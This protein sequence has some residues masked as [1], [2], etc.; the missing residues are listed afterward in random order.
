MSLI[1]KYYV[2][3]LNV[4]VKIH[5]VDYPDPRLIGLF[6]LVLASW[7]NRGLTVQSKKIADFSVCRNS[8]N[9]SAR[10]QSN[11]WISFTFLNK[12]LKLLR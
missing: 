11:Y 3:R 9:S 1:C 12:V 10:H 7:D 6:H 8:E 4:F 2:S 5:I